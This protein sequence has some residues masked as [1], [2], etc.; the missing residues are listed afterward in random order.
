MT[1]REE[2]QRDGRQSSLSAINNCSRAGVEPE[3]RR[4]DD[5]QWPFLAVRPLIEAIISVGGQEGLKNS[6]DEN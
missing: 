4:D 6:R 3:P 1:P 5:E 2:T